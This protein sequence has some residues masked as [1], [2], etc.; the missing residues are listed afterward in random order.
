M[1]RGHVD[2]AAALLDQAQDFWTR[3]PQRYAE[4]RLEGLG[5]RARLQR[6][7][8]DLNG[9]IATSREAIAART[10][11]SGH[12]HRETAVLY[13]S[14][15]ITLTSANRLGEALAAYRETMSIYRAVGLGDGLDA[16]VVLA[17][18]GTLE[19][20][21]GHLHESETLLKTAIEHERALAGDSAAAAA[22][23]GQYGKVLT[24]ENRI[25]EA[26]T[27]L[28]EGLNLA[29][30]YAGAKSPVTLQNEI[31]FGEAQAASGDR[32]R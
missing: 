28:R 32:W 9:A 12:D 18:M 30:R 23:T 20:R 24:V 10:A 25:P 26:L 19:M 4:E 11:L 8:G 22:A 2:R 6:T 17:N 7:Q 5:I 15:A 3:A 27:V 1:M 29:E 31:F 13:N 14:L 16:Q 21:T